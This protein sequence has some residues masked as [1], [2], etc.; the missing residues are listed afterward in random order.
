MES[1][2][3]ST[4]TPPSDP[5]NPSTVAWKHCAATP[6]DSA[7]SPNTAGA[8]CTRLAAANPAS[9]IHRTI[10]SSASSSR[11]GRFQPGTK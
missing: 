1:A 10:R 6:S 9:T 4:T 8:H 5:P 11:T 3:S 2:S 7:T